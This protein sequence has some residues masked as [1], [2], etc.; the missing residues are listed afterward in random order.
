MAPAS[1][2]HRRGGPAA[3]RRALLPGPARSTRSDRGSARP[4]R[5]GASSRRRRA[6]NRS[7]SPHPPR[8]RERVDCPS[9]ALVPADLLAQPLAQAALGTRVR[10]VHL[11]ANS[12]AGQ[13]GWI[14]DPVADEQADQTGIRPVDFLGFAVE[15]RAETGPAGIAIGRD[16][17]A[18]VASLDRPDDHGQTRAPRSRASGSHPRRGGTPASGR[19][20]WARPPRPPRPSMRR[21]RVVNRPGARAGP[22][23]S[24]PRA[25]RRSAR[26]RGG[27][28][29]AALPP[30]SSRCR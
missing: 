24:R 17:V 1:A 23:G 9:P 14:A 10:D 21:D 25:R 6:R 28:G 2:P 11:G 7:G 18:A 22:R 4:P 29:C 3:A 5:S 19:T 20:R 27:R 8:S 16:R 13:A 15:S 26:P 30:A 12:A